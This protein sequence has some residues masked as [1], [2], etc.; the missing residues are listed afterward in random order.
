[1]NNNTNFTSSQYRKLPDFNVKNLTK[2]LFDVTA[3]RCA[4]IISESNK[5]EQNK[6]TQIRRFYDELVMWNERAG[7][8]QEA[9]QNALPFI[10]MIKSKVAYAEGR[11]TVDETFKIFMGTVIDQ[12]DDVKTLNNAKLFMEAV[13]G[14]YKLYKQD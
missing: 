7:I 8:S 13:M 6:S 3:D 12:I 11:G 4:K 14:F 9:F 5:K 10:F 1:M 2:E